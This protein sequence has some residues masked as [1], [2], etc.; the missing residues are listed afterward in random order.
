MFFVHIEDISNT[1]TLGWYSVRFSMMAPDGLASPASS[2]LSCLF[3]FYVSVDFF[4]IRPN[5][6][7]L[8][9]VRDGS[10]GTLFLKPGK[11]RAERL[12]NV[13]SRIPEYSTYRSR[14]Q[15]REPSAR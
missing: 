5:S 1:T 2:S 7:V 6:S 8:Q 3:V 12:C 14:P 9:E 11:R 4:V 13:L 10:K 15:V